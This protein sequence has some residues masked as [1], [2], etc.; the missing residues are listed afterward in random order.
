MQRD[1]A[2]PVTE[3][4]LHAWL[5]GQLDPQRRRQVTLHLDAHPDDA[6]RVAAWRA[7]Q[8]G[9]RAS[10]A[11]I[12]EEPLP[13]HLLAAARNRV[14]ATGATATASAR[15]ADRCLAAW[16]RT[17]MRLVR[18]TLGPWFSRSQRLAAGLAF[19]FMGVAVGWTLRG[20]LTS[21]APRHAP[22]VIGAAF[23]QRA[24]IA[25]AV[26]APE[27][28]R[29]VEIDAAHE[30]QLVTW[31]SNRMGTPM[32]PAHLQSL[33]YTLEGGRLLPGKKG[34]VAQFMYRD[35]DNQRLTLYISNKMAFERTDDAHAANIANPARERPIS[36]GTQ[37]NADSGAMPHAGTP[38]GIAFHFLE[39]E[40]LNVF[41][42]ID[43][44]F[45][46]ALSAPMDR[47]HLAQVSHQIYH[48]LVGR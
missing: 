30:V 6:R 22:D 5:D 14:D 23:A 2:P 47:A 18:R 40:D 10:A 16:L 34:P 26:Y 32:R 41:Y 15:H 44:T 36:A 45:G 28:R 31:L 21:V 42:W 27:A 17:R 38:Q 37:A 29:P 39:L 25:H 33:G 46:Y 24:A 1:P 48:Q 13:A 11:V 3:F 9:I 35:A 4:E 43:G 7:Q 20:D 19:T 12:D 8:E